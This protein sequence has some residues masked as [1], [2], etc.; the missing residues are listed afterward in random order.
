TNGLDPAGMAE[1]RS[2]IRDLGTGDRTVLLS[3]HL[4]AEMEQI[5]DRIGIISGGRMVAE[6]T[7]DELRGE[8]RL[9]IRADPSDVARD[10]VTSIPGIA[11]VDVDREGLHLRVRDHA[12]VDPATVNA[13]L[14]Q[15]GIAVSGLQWE[16]S[17]LESVFL[18]LTSPEGAAADNIHRDRL[19]EVT[20][21]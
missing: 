5:C 10:I 3:S 21:A 9:L 6:G 18:S 7:V 16:R 2:L 13:R 11:S 17:S 19:M 15:Q 20:H 14:V 8:D 4:M 12:T 1:M